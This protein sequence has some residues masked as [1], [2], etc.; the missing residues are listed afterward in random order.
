M[1]SDFDFDQTMSLTEYGQFMTA[2]RSFA[3]QN[4]AVLDVGVVADDDTVSFSA[5]ILID[6]VAQPALLSTFFANWQAQ[7]GV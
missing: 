7:Q 4:G 5:T 1:S 6:G 3:A 2:L